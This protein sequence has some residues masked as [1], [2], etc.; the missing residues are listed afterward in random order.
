MTPPAVA[1]PISSESKSRVRPGPPAPG[2]GPAAA[3][4]ASVDSAI[5]IAAAALDRPDT[6]LRLIIGYKKEPGVRVGG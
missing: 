5:V 1:S 3:A 4:A 2:P 6:Q